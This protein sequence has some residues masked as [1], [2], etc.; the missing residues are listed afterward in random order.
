MLEFKFKSK[1]N[2]DSNPFQGAAASRG[3]VA[4]D[5]ITKMSPLASENNNCLFSLPHHPQPHSLAQVRYSDY[6]PAESLTGSTVASRN[7]NNIHSGAS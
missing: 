5:V 7:V 2:F 4:M 6:N 3:A 1:Y